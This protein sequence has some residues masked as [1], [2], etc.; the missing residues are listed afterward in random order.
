MPN[1]N[2]GPTVF[3]VDDD[4]S[5]LRA[6][7]RLVRSGGFRVEAFRSPEELLRQQNP[8]T[9]GCL[10][11]EVTMPVLNGFDL[12]QSL[13]A[14]GNRLPIIFLSGTDSVS[15]AVLAM[16]SGA[17]D[18]LSKPCPDEVLMEAI[19][20]AIE[21][22]KQSRNRAVDDAALASLFARLTPR[23]HQVMLGV[24]AGKEN[25][26]IAAE[27]GTVEKTVKV[28][29]ARVMEKL[30]VSSVADLTRL[31]GRAGYDGV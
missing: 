1:K 9:P 23:E 5:V 13:A 29:R 11:L 15:V 30:N 22:D 26:I 7:K 24:V 8:A 14:A 18:F 4:P 3:L 25:K 19:S 20:R 10:V 6:I 21:K 28:H 31:S 16:K 27:L 17:V 12:K 2:A